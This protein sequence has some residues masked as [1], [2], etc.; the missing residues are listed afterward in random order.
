MSK[1][2]IY[3]NR[4]KV[5]NMQKIYTAFDRAKELGFTSTR[6]FISAYAARNNH[7]WNGQIDNDPAH[8]LTAHIDAGRWA[9]ECECGQ[10]AYADPDYPVAFCAVCGNFAVGGLGRVII[11]PS[12][13]DRAEIE[14]VLLEREIS[15]P[16]DFGTQSILLPISHPKIEKLHRA[17]L[18]GQSVD[19]LRNE[20]KHARAPKGE[21]DTLSLPAVLRKKKA[22]K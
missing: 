17:W 18:P 19:D 20:N 21:G 8:G 7:P 12:L 22:G 14:S 13:P 11:F 4:Q 3:P 16:F 2:F 10:G 9:A 6:D 15:A 5:N 1:K